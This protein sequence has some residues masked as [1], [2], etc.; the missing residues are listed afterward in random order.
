MPKLSPPERYSALPRREVVE[1]TIA[2]ALASEAIATPVKATADDAEISAQRAKQ[3]RQ[4]AGD[5]RASTLIL[6]AQR[7][8]D[9]R[10]ALTDLMW[11]EAGDGTRS[12][13]Q[14]LD[15]IARMIR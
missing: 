9:L 2:E 5:P 4:E 7:R 10:A 15:Q 13:A 11:A 6:L 12:P 8:P 1:R 14:I 3:L